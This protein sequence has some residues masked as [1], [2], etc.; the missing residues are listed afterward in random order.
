M[1]GHTNDHTPRRGCQPV[2]PVRSS[3]P[4]L[5]LSTRCSTNY[6]D[7]DI[8]E[9]PR[10]YFQHTN[11]RLASICLIW[12]L[13]KWVSWIVNVN[14]NTTKKH[15]RKRNSWLVDSSCFLPRMSPTTKWQVLGKARSTRKAKRSIFNHIRPGTILTL[16]EATGLQYGQEQLRSEINFTKFMTLNTFFWKLFF[17]GMTK[18]FISLYVLFQH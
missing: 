6:S 10:V 4:S 8:N 18:K 15:W 2:A 5:L 17:H 9:N 7:R 16:T 13:I 1:V 3:S 12:S 11:Q 14:S